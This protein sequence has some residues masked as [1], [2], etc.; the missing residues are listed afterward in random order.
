[1]RYTGQI[2]SLLLLA[3]LWLP[4]FQHLTQTWTVR[5]LAG[6]VPHPEPPAL[7]A[8]GFFNGTLQT[9]TA[10]YLRDRVGFQPALV[11][12]YNEFHYR[13]H[14]RARANGVAIG[15]DPASGTP[16]LFETDYIRS[17]RGQDGV[18]AAEV[19]SAADRLLTVTRSFHER[20]IPLLTVLA[21]NKAR[22]WPEAVPEGP[23]PSQTG[24]YERWKSALAARDLAYLDADSLLRSWRDTTAHPLFSPTGIHWT[25]YAAMQFIPHLLE[26]YG[27]LAHRPMPRF[28][29]T[30]LRTPGEA[31]W[32]DDDIEQGMNIWT[33]LPDGPLTYGDYTWV[34]APGGPPGPVLVTGDSFYWA[35]FNL[36]CS[37]E[38]F[39]GG[40]FA[41]Y[42]QAVYPESYDQPTAQVDLLG[43]TGIVLLFTD[44]TF[45][46]SLLPFLSDAEAQLAGLNP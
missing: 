13:V 42:H 32:N 44:A 41:F 19:D 10:S 37:K 20:G 27:A 4:A 12:T 1:M 6:D 26:R 5:P 36:G 43:Q 11:R 28:T 18:R 3:A 46:K 40:S 8:R 16:V 34:A 30:A 21:P 45:R 17:L 9:A 29:I 7:T 14:S 39:A 38:G 2:A 31:R 25:R 22:Y 35:L 33:D 15:T 23:A 24:T